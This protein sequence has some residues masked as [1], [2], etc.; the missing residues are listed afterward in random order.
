MQPYH[1]VSVILVIMC[2]FMKVYIILVINKSI[3]ILFSL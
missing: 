3:G 2:V 1:T